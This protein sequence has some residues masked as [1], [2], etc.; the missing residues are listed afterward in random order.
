MA[1][2]IDFKV[3]VKLALSD[4]EA[5]TREAVNKLAKELQEAERANVTAA[6]MG[7]YAKGT[8]VSVRGRGR[9][10]EIDVKSRPNWMRAHEYGAVS[11][12][13]P[14]LWIPVPGAIFRHMRA[15]GYPQK[16][17]RPPNSNVLINVKTRKVAY[18]GIPRANIRP[19]LD[20]RAI[21]EEKAAKFVEYFGSY[22]SA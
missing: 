18:I 3:E 4:F 20:M 8:T 15:K 11:V 16:L 1:E 9:N 12:G 19:R 5:V 2:K 22:A 6:G 21:A 10:W 17:Y 7:K 14:M 13:Q